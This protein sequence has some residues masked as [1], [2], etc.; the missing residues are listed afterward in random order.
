[1]RTPTTL[2]ALAVLATTGCSPAALQALSSAANAANAGSTKPVT[3]ASTAPSPAASADTTAN[4]NTGTMTNAGG[5]P[6]TAQT[7]TAFK[8]KLADALPDPEKVARLFMVAFAHYPTDKQLAI[9]LMMLCCTDGE[10]QADA[11]SPTG[12]TA[13]AARAVYWPGVDRQPTLPGLYFDTPEN[14]T[15]AD[16]EAHVVIDKEYKAVDQGVQGDLAT[17]YMAQSGD[18]NKRP[19]PLRLEKK[20]DG[21]RVSNYSSVVVPI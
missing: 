4:V 15:A 14:A 8:A 9:G 17:F 20:A 2:L 13:P 7:V 11:S 1:M 21:W 6:A 12:F 18:A 5:D 10:R 3:A 16:A 19:R